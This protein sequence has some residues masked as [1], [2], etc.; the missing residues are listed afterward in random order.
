MDG[1]SEKRMRFYVGT[2]M[3]S[4]AKHLR[5]SMISV[6]RL[7]GRKSDFQAQHW[8]MDSAAFT[9]ISTHG[10]HYP[11]EFYAEQV[12]RWSKCG[13]IDAA[14]SQDYMCESFI[15]AK[16]GKTVEEHHALT[17]ERYSVLRP[18]VKSA[19]LMPV[20]QGFRPDE[21]ISH[22]RQYGSLLG[23]GQ[24]VGVG[25]V[26]KR[27]TDIGQIRSVLHA[28]KKERPT[29]KLHGFGLKQT[30]LSD[31]F[32]RQCLFSADSMAWS[33]AARK[34]GRNANGLEEALRFENQIQNQP[35]QLGL[36]AV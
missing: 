8:I 20:L 30:A 3:V 34:N 12:E 6:N 26:C 5:Y 35:Y 18:L 14:V 17:I 21:Y 15:L 32:V 16:T 31:G 24:W 10:E 1:G 36:W 29:L 25:S 4:H 7:I 2:H 23:H 9:R 33:F 13:L 22:L 11:V 28:I 19:Y 27:N